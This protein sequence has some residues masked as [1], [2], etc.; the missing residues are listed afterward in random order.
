ML[1]YINQM[2]ERLVTDD[3]TT[4]SGGLAFNLGNALF[5][6]NVKLSGLPWLP[7]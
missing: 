7:G 1:Y 5:Y 3:R 6:H 4:L 2:P